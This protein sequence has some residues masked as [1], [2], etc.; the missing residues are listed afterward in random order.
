MIE[1]KNVSNYIYV[2]K[3]FSVICSDV[4]NRFYGKPLRDTQLF[5]REKLN[6]SNEKPNNYI[7]QNRHKGEKRYVSN[8][9]ILFNITKMIYP[10]YNW[11]NDDV[12]NYDLYYVSKFFNSIYCLVCP[13][14][15][16]VANT[17]FMQPKTITL[18]IFSNWLD[19]PAMCS[20]ISCEVYMVVYHTDGNNHWAFNANWLVQYAGFIDALARTVS[21]FSKLDNST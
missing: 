3:I 10:K 9:E 4:G 13:T 5:L 12:V 20:C 8:W 18:V 19:V 16:N 17:I 14:G 7:F 2:D 1:F 6:L 15:S 21:L 11:K